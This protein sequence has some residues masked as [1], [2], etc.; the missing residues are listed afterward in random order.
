MAYFAYTMVG[1]GLTPVL[2]AAF[3]WKRTN[4]PGAVASLAGGMVTTI[5][6]AMMG[7][8]AEDLMLPSLGVSVLALI[9]VSLASR[10]PAE[11]KWKPFVG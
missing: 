10:P 1:A 7:K 9:V 2:L 6:G 5:V 11:D 4:G 8:A 3:L